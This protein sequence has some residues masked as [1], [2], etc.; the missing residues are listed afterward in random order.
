VSYTLFGAKLQALLP[1]FEA[2]PQ[3]AVLRQFDIDPDEA[4]TAGGKGERV[5]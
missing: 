1:E 5:V 3:R 4:M 2:K